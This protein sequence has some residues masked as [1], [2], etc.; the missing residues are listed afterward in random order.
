M[1]QRR[2]GDGAVGFAAVRVLALAFAALLSGCKSAPLI[3]GLVSGSAVG[4]ATANPA[5]G[6]AVGVAASAATDTALRYYGRTRHQAE[7]DAIAAVAG[8]LDVGG[9]RP[10]KIEH[11]IPYGDAHGSLQVVRL[12]VSPLATCKEIAFSVDDGDTVAAP[13][14][15]YVTQVCQQGAVWKWAAA[16][17]A[18]ERWGNLQ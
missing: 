15:W 9:R 10:W 5:V 3:V 17:P 11:D 12:I 6:F 14:A 7:Q 4:G 2:A 1:G 8:G 18:V 13:R 16:D